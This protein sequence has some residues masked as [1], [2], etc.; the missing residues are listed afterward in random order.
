MKSLFEQTGG[1]YRTEKNYLIPKLI[2]PTENKAIGI[3]GRRHLRYLKENRKCTYINLLTSGLLNKYLAG[4]DEQ[5][6]ERF[7]VLMQQM[8]QSQGITEEM[9]ADNQIEWVGKINNIKHTIEEI[10]NQELVYM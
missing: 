5:A 4:I 9:K 6:D 1:T 10:I 2:L 3:Y 8:K 7:G